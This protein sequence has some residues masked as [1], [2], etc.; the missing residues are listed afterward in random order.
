M[1]AECVLMCDGVQSEATEGSQLGAEGG[2]PGTPARHSPPRKFPTM[3]ALGGGGSPA[4][5]TSP[6]VLRTLSI[7][8]R[9]VFL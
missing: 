6:S 3:S 5:D 7:S 9:S 1:L 4:S 2:E 8:G